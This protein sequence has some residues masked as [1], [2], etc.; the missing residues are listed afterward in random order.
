MEPD[1]PKS[2]LSANYG[3]WYMGR[4][5][6]PTWAEWAVWARWQNLNRSKFYFHFN[7]KWLSGDNISWIYYHLYLDK[8]FLLISL[9]D[10]CGAQWSSV[11]CIQW[12]F[13]VLIPTQPPWSIRF[14]SDRIETLSVSKDK[15][16]WFLPDLVTTFETCQFSGIF[17]KIL[18]FSWQ[19][20]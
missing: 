10:S 15:P 9:R 11:G 4:K 8:K 20:E 2:T 6:H 13:P 3:W 7:E 17:Q 14:S 5:I 12:L 16:L 19:F 18:A 1:L